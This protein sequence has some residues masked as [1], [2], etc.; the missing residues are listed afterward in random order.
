MYHFITK[1]HKNVEKWK[2]SK[3]LLQL[4]PMPDGLSLVKLWIRQVEIVKFSAKFYVI[5]FEK[6][7]I[8]VIQQMNRALLPKNI[9]DEW[10][11]MSITKRTL[12]KKGQS[13]IMEI[14]QALSQTS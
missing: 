13:K 6:C 1:G 12:S 11:Q 14:L 10:P 9:K 7:K 2:P 4:N 5:C 8:F 3:F